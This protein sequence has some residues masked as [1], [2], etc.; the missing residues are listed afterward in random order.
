[1]A[2]DPTYQ[3]AAQD[4]AAAFAAADWEAL[5]LAEGAS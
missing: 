5:R 3:A 4:I 1:M 2:R